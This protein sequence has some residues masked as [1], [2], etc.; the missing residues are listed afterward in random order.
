MIVSPSPVPPRVIGALD[1]A[2]VGAT[3]TTGGRDCATLR[4]VGPD[5]WVYVGCPTRV[6][7]TAA[8]LAAWGATLDG[9]RC[10]APGPVLDWGTE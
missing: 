4:K 6:I 7:L 3:A 5:S 8:Q 10:P 1:R 2:P 9:S